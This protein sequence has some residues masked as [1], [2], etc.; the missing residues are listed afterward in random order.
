MGSYFLVHDDRAIL[1]V[2]IS[3][4]TK[5]ESNNQFGSE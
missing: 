3:S 4:L 2:A 1:Y 5:C